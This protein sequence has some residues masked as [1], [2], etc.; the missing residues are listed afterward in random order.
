MDFVKMI[1]E[2]VPKI[3]T[4]T[5]RKNESFIDSL[6]FAFHSNASL[7]SRFTVLPIAMSLGNLIGSTDTSH[8]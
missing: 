5:K 3:I 1:A 7:P 8:P 4:A 6:L 2:A